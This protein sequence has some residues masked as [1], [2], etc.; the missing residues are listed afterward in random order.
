MRTG[1][2]QEPRPESAII[3]RRLS[4]LVPIL[5]AVRSCTRYAAAQLDGRRTGEARRLVAA[6]RAAER[7]HPPLRVAAALGGYSCCEAL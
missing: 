1:I 4:V 5:E 2:V 7:Q 6:Q 3:H